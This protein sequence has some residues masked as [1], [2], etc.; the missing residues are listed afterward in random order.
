MSSPGR[1]TF[2]RPHE[3]ERPL[4]DCEDERPPC[5]CED[6]RHAT[7][8]ATDHLQRSPA[9]GLPTAAVPFVR[10]ASHLCSSDTCQALSPKCAR[11][12]G[13]AKWH[14]PFAR[15][16]ATHLSVAAWARALM[17]PAGPTPL[18]MVCR[19]AAALS[20]GG[21]VSANGDKVES[22]EVA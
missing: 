20:A 6:K 18:P 14:V 2:M 7:E 3:D 17:R 4:C 21:S 15:A 11:W 16:R 8:H 19:P 1:P 13:S 5:D 12:C 22:G 9:V 10:A